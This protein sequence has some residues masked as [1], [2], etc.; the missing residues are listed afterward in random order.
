[1]IQQLAC[2][3]KI[4]QDAQIDLDRLAIPPIRSFQP[5]S[6]AVKDDP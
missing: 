4:M 2:G 6:S 5:P 1:M 3:W